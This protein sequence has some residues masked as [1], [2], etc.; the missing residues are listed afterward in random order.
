MLH[1]FLAPKLRF[2]PKMLGAGD[3]PPEPLE[4]LH[5]CEVA[6]IRGHVGSRSPGPGPE[7]LLG[8]P[9]HIGQ[10]GQPSTG[11][12]LAGMAGGRGHPALCTGRQRRG[13]LRRPLAWSHLPSD[14]AASVGVR[15][16]GMRGTKLGTDR[17]AGA[18][19]PELLSLTLPSTD[20]APTS[21]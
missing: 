4:G 9:A 15:E 21:P 20:S 2:C 14:M 6:E 7:Y 3:F 17:A 16:T 19:T 13:R 12:P 11:H 8:W 18:G 1:P 5:F 10:E